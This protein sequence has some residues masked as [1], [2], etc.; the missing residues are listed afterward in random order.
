MRTVILALAL[1]GLASAASAQP[2]GSFDPLPGQQRSLYRFDLQKNFY[3]DND[4]WLHDGIVVRDAAWGIEGLKGKVIESAGNLLKVMQERQRAED[5]LVKLFAY[6]EFRQAVDTT[7]VQAYRTY[8]HLRSTFDARTSFVRVEL[9]SLKPETLDAFIKEKP[10]LAKYRFIIEDALRM[11]KYTLSGGEEKILALLGPDLTSW[12]FPL[13]NKVFD[14]TPFPAVTVDGKTYDAYRD[15]DALLQNPDRSAREAAWKGTYG[16]FAKMSGMLAFSLLQEIKSYNDEAKLRGF[17]DYYAESLYRR[18]LTRGQVGSLYSQ[19]ERKLSLY[20]SYQE[21]RAA[22]IARDYGIAAPAVWDM[23]LPPKTKELPRFTAEEGIALVEQSLKVLGPEYS[24]DLAALLDPKNGRLDIAGGPGRQQGAFT[25]GHFGYFMDNYQGLLDNVS[26]MAHE[27]GHAVHHE[28]V[29]DH[30]GSGWFSDG[31]GYMTESFAMFNEWLLRDYLLKTEK[32]PARLKVYRESALHE[33]MY[34]WELA[35]RAKFEMVAY[36]LQAKGE[37]RDEEGLNEICF[38]TGRPYDPFFDT[39]GE[40][41]FHWIRKHHYWSVPTYYINYVVAQLL[42]LTYYQ[43]Y[44]ADP[45]G[46]PPKYVAMVS[47]GF[48]KPPEELLKGY[49]GIDLEDPQLLDGVFAMIQQEYQE[50]AG[51]GAKTKPAK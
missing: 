36:D 34:L 44:L 38:Q 11:A 27:A 35:R 33:M 31:P 21:Y 42:S 4:A 50:V 47:A 46:F 28:L 29:A 25:E 32:D 6:G 5:T 12:Q 18:Y 7:D 37:L 39:N 15:L 45:K 8:L 49:L 14:Q 24:K 13:F 20:R 10:A 40:M 51:G 2:T 23:E 41:K 22:E 16:T 19:L 1:L 3:A 30:L 17:D 48:E 43:H 9:K 26:T